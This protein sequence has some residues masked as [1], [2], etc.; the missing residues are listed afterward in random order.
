[1]NAKQLKFLKQFASLSRVDAVTDEKALFA[2]IKEFL[3]LDYALALDVWEFLTIDKEGTLADDPDVA[4]VFADKLYAMF[5][6]KNAQRTVKAVTELPSV[7]RA[8]FQYSPSAAKGDFFD[9]AVDFAVANKTQI[10]DEIFKC[11]SKNDATGTTFGAYM[12]TLVERMFIEILKK[13]ADKKI[14]MNKKM[15]A[16]LLSHIAK[17]KTEEKALLQQRL[18]EIS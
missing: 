16:L 17:I 4:A 18:R 8:V 6:K 10:C 3:E 1:M 12:K 11:V 7:R 5:L 15:Q 9:I 2:N 13:S 14:V